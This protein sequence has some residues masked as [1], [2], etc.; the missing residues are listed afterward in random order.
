MRNN[1]A[2]LAADEM[3]LEDNL[4]ASGRFWPALLILK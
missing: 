1:L 2:L 4:K 3:R